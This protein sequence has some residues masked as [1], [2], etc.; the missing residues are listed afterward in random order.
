MGRRLWKCG[1]AFQLPDLAREVTCS[2][3]VDWFVADKMQPHL[4]WS[5]R[6]SETVEA[7][8]RALGTPRR[9]SS[10]CIYSF[11]TPFTTLSILPSCLTQISTFSY[12][13]RERTL[14][15]LYG[16]HRSPS[17]HSAD[18]LELS[19]PALRSGARR[20]SANPRGG[21]QAFP[22]PFMSRDRACARE[23][24]I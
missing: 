20:A 16:V 7:A 10:F 8:A 19:S 18:K 1:C 15:L 6:G 23:T 12:A 2:N 13:P 9:D 3:S 11:D 17:R 14:I 24:G 21:R 4:F 5:R 22:R